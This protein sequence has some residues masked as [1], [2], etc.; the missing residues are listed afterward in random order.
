V[1]RRKELLLADN[2]TLSSEKAASRTSDK[3]AA[4]EE[5]VNGHLL[6]IK[7]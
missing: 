3:T 6:Q 2:L 4:I 1:T 5:D 7:L